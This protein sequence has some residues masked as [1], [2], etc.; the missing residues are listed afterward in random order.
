MQIFIK[1]LLGDLI[2]LE[3]KKDETIKDIKLKVR[4]R[5]GIQPEDQVI[6]FDD[7]KYF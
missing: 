1:T 3:V 5:D 4:L 2:T 7:E 6:E